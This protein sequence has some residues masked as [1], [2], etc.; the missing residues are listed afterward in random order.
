MFSEA[1]IT[2]AFAERHLKRAVDYENTLF[3]LIIRQDKLFYFKSGGFQASIIMYFSEKNGRTLRM[4]SVKNVS[5]QSV[6]CSKD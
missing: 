5:S 6:K 4:L 1:N 2:N 3:N